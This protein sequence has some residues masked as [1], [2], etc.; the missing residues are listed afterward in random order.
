MKEEPK[1]FWNFCG[2]QCKKTIE[3]YCVSCKTNNKNEKSSDRKTKQN[4]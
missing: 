3:S 2:K 4:R 1:K